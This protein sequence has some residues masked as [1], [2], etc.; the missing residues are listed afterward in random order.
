MNGAIQK[1]LSGLKSAF[2]PVLHPRRHRARKR[3]N[4]NQDFL[5]SL[6]FKEIEDGDLSY[7]DAEENALRLVQSDAAQITFIVV[8]RRRSRA[9][10]KLDKKGRY[11]SYTGPIRI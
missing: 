6:G 2:E 1:V 7:I 4:R 11:T 9:Y 5:K 8:G 10:I 3:V